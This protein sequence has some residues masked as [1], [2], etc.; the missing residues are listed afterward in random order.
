MLVL[1][2]PVCAVQACQIAEKINVLTR[3]LADYQLIDTGCAE[4]E[5]AIFEDSMPFAEREPLLKEAV[6]SSIAATKNLR[7]AQR[8]QQ[9]YDVEIRNLRE[10]SDRDTR[11]LLPLARQFD[12]EVAS[13]KR[14]EKQWSERIRRLVGAAPAAGGRGGSA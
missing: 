12:V 3:Y 8:Q 6:L 10:K 2:A 11:P 13:A 1:T 4:W 7:E 14:L 5:L 9:A